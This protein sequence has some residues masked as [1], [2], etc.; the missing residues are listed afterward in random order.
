MAAPPDQRYLKL[1]E[2]YRNQ[3]FT[4]VSR[5]FEEVRDTERD[6]FLRDLILVA[7][8]DATSVQNR[9]LMALR[10]FCLSPAGRGILSERVDFPEKGGPVTLFSVLQNGMAG[11]GNFGSCFATVMLLV[12]SPPQLDDL[13]RQLDPEFVAKVVFQAFSAE[14]DNSRIMVQMLGEL[15]PFAEKHTS[16]GLYRGVVRGHQK[17]C[18]FCAGYRRRPAVQAAGSCG[19]CPVAGASLSAGKPVESGPVSG[20]PGPAV[21]RTMDC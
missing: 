4:A 5:L 20:R 11:S 6:Q 15:L 10:G 9:A 13:I 3:H 1:R 14:R 12:R 16:L 18:P 21:H 7:G 17:G 19:P 2:L 8:E